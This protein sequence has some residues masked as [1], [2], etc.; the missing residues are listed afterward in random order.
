MAGERVPAR[1]GESERPVPKVRMVTREAKQVT[2]AKEEQGSA[3]A[4]KSQVEKKPAAEEEG[5]SVREFL[6]WRR[7]AKSMGLIAVELIAVRRRWR[8]RTRNRQ[9]LAIFGFLEF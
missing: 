8:A 2:P 7:A 6:I 1:P 4:E 9:L 5:M 3:A